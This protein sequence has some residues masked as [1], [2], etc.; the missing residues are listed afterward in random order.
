MLASQL[1][2][3]R[4]TIEAALSMLENEGLLVPQGPGR[5]RKIELPEELAKPP[6]LRVAILLY[7]QSDQTLDYLIDCKN[8]L[9]TAGHTVFYAPSHLTEIKMDVRRLAR[10]VKKTEADAWVVLGGTREVLQW[11]MQQKT[12]AS[13]DSG[14]RRRLKIAGIGPDHVPA[15]TEATRQLV[16]LGHQRIV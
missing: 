14:R 4:M 2:V 5:R 13:A 16:D 9:E 3:G 11:F 6:G 10:M 12:P 7:E 8:K 1:G 15:L